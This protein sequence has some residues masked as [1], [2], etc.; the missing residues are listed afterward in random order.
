MENE[1]IDEHFEHFVF[2]IRELL[3]F[4]GETGAGMDTELFVAGGSAITRLTYV[5]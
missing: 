5:P 3:K 1:T 4:I 2:T